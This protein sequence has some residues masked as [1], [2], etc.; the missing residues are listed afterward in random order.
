MSHSLALPATMAPAETA[1][2][3]EAQPAWRLP[4]RPLKIAAAGTLLMAGAYGA[5][6]EQIFIS[7]SDAVVSAYVLDVRAPIEGVVTGLPRGNNAAIAQGDLLAAMRNSLVDHQHLDNLRTLEETAGSNAAADDVELAELARQRNGLLL[8]A[9]A[10][11][12]AVADR[13]VHAT[14]EAKSTLLGREQALAQARR[15]L[16][17]GT[18]LHDA[19]II[20]HAEYDRLVT[21]ESIAARNVEAER[22][23]VVSLESQRS[24]ASH[25]LLSEPG[26]NNDV[27]Y[28]HQRADELATRI[29]EVQ[30]S[31]AA[32]RAQAAQAHAAVSA[33]GERSTQ[34]HGLD[35]RSPIN[36]EV[37]QVD[38][39]DGERMAAGDPLLT[40]VD[41]SR[42][43]LLVEVPQD[44]LPQLAIG[45]EARFRLAGETAERTGTVLSASGDPQK[46]VNHKFAAFPMQD[47]SKELATVRVSMDVSQAGGRAACSVGRAAHVMLPTVPSSLA[48]RTVRRWF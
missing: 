30:R 6:S 10:H 47:T 11:A 42:Q 15:D 41:C 12:T 14:A 29:A 23:A 44:R 45:G 36:G 32:S 40:M 37:W 39:M 27:A 16:Q 48:S 3:A 25:G 4:R 1:A 22:E 24:A 28:S 2:A 5:F 13:L 20:P 9:D 46:E 26:T 31:L 38:A 21:A 35:V 8:R 7:S 33:E 19:G 17:R 43:F 34:L 18:A